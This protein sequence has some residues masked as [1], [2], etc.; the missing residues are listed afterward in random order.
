VASG[1]LKLA[2]F[3]EGIRAYIYVMRGREAT[4]DRMLWNCTCLGS[5]ALTEALLSSLMSEGVRL[6]E[7]GEFHQTSVSGGQAGRNAGGGGAEDH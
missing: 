7:P 5:L 4:R 2:G 1:E 6:A 3:P